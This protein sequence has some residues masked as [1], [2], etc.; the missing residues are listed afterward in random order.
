M[1][2]LLNAH[3]FNG[4]MDE[5][6]GFIMNTTILKMIHTAHLESL[7]LDGETIQDHIIHG[8]IVMID[9]TNLIYTFRLDD[10]TAVF[11]ITP[12]GKVVQIGAD[13]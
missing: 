8:E 11:K 5:L 6:E 2:I 13:F 1:S 9:F 10:F 3:A 4:I 7:K 12:N